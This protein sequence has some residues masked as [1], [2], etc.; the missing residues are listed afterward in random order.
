M[1]FRW[2]AVL[3]FLA[4][5]MLVAWVRHYA[6]AHAVLDHPNARSAHAVPTPR[7]GGLAIVAVVVAGMLWLGLSDELPVQVLAGFVPAALAVAGV[8]WLDDRRGLA[9]RWRAGVHVLASAWLLLWLGVP[10]W[11]DFLPLVLRALSWLLAL[12]WLINLINFMDGLDGLAASEVIFISTASAG[13]LMAV[14]AGP[15]SLLAILLAV[16]SLG[17]LVW[18]HPPA[19]IFMGDV[20]SGFLGLALG[21][22]LLLSGPDLPRL[23]WPFLILGAAFWVDATATLLWRMRSGERWYAAHSQHAYQHLA[24]RWQSHRAVLWAEMGLNIFWLL[25]LALAAW[26]M[27]SLAPGL[28]FLAILP[29]LFAWWRLGGGRL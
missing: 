2:L 17:F 4:S 26:T 25:P 11:P 23:V 19:R 6:L 29:L 24:R 7:G 3:A 21:A 20:G 13:F 8:G 14:V 15:A 1:L 9:A 18:N 28:T 10:A 5:V 16:A 22:L 27:P 12:V